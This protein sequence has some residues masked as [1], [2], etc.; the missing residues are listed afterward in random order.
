MLLTLLPWFLLQH[1]TT[2]LQGALT[3]A[4]RGRCVLRCNLVM[5][6]ALAPALALAAAS[7]SLLLFAAARAV[8]E[9]ARLAALLAALPPE[10]RAALLPKPC[11]PVPLPQLSPDPPSAAAP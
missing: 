6:T 11:R 7:G 1:P 5:V 2:L 10:A 8:G 4:G 3:A 9:A